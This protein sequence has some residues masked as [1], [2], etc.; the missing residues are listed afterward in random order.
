LGEI[1]RKSGN[2]A[3]P[4]DPAIAQAHMRRLE[5][6]VGCDAANLARVRYRLGEPG[7]EFSNLVCAI[8]C[9]CL[10]VQAKRA[11]VPLWVL[12]GGRLHDC[13]PEYHSIGQAAPQAMAA[14]AERVQAEGCRVIQMKVGGHDDIVLDRQRIEAIIEV[15]RDDALMLVDANG[16]WDVATAVEFMGGI[17]DR[18]LLWEEPCNTYAENRRAAEITEAPIL[19]DQCLGGPTVAAR[20]CADGLV[21]GLSIK[22]TLQAG[23]LAARLA[24]DLAIA[25]GLKLKIDDSWGADVGTALAL[26]LAM[27]VPADLL[28]CAIDMRPYFTGRIAPDGPVSS[29]FRLMPSGEAGLGLSPDLK[30]LGPGLS[31][32][33]AATCD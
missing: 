31:I 13:V 25:H 4:S 5:P 26:H 16:G 8:E 22:P 32:G 19:L 18:R 21:C 14:E 28:I 33:S 17:R 2:T 20:A 30:R 24:R 10:D 15:M 6:V 7:P 12:L 1:C 29:G 9:A 27:A 23:P 11:G 3:A